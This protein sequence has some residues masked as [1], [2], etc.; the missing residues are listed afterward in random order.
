MR[1]ITKIVTFVFLLLSVAELSAQSSDGQ[2]SS[3]KS[4]FA[5]VKPQP[6]SPPNQSTILKFIS[7]V[8]RSARGTP[9]AGYFVFTLSDQSEK[10]V[11][12]AQVIKIVTPTKIPNDITNASDLGAVKKAIEY[13]NTVGQTFPAAAQ[14]VAEMAKP[15]LDAQSKFDAGMIKIDGTWQSAAVHQKESVAKIESK[16]NQDIYEAITSKSLKSFNLDSNN[17]YVEL[18]AIAKNDPDLATR[19]EATKARYEGLRAA[20]ELQATLAKIN[21]PTIGSDTL[22]EIILKLKKIPAP[23]SR[24]RRILE[25]SDLATQ[26]SDLSREIKN[27]LEL[28][29]ANTTDPAIPLPP[30]NDIAAKIQKIDTDVTI[31]KSGNPPA[32]L[33]IP[34]KDIEAEIFYYKNIT[35]LIPAIKSRDYSKAETFVTPL[36]E[37]S[38]LIGPKTN[39]SMKAIL[40]VVTTKL[41]TFTKLRDEAAMLAQAGKK[42]EAIAKYTEAINT[43]PDTQISAKIE[44][45]KKSNPPAK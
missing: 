42:K 26:I 24:I 33:L 38:T 23:D 16:L 5:L 43:I 4:G 21:D 25:Q 9:G 35:N 11:A 22:S 27:G 15:L 44:E 10:Q 1:L 39:E 14:S 45:L 7:Y 3:E 40:S 20:D 36:V 29:Y 13:Y 8:D 6:W 18:L 37:A 30:S 19:L 12:S 32:G 31:F 17:Y 28:Q 2:P 34:A 41:A